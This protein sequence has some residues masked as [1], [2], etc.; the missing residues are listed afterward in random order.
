V[1]ALICDNQLFVK[2]TEAGKHYIGQFVEV[3]AYPGARPSLLIEEQIED[4]EWL[5]TLIL[6]TEREL[7]TPK[8][9]PKKKPKK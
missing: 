1:V 4:S 2:P 5:S 8:K 3:P 6:I 9:K 7:P